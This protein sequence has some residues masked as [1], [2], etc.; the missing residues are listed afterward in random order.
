V[1]HAAYRTLARRHHPDT[2]HDRHA[3]ERIRAIN[4]AY[5]V[6]GNP[7]RRAQYDAERARASRAR[8]DRPKARTSGGGRG[9][10]RA[11][12]AL[13]GQGPPVIVVRVMLV[14][15]AIILL[16]AMLWGISLV[17]DMLEDTPPNLPPHSSIGGFSVLA[18]YD[19]L[20][21]PWVVSQPESWG[22]QRGRQGTAFTERV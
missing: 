15:V 22:T 2:S 5:E 20:A 8:G 7:V 17:Y 10:V 16:L 9:A 11:T 4:A 19:R 12:S 14:V 21:Q 18:L 1:I 13:A 3:A 6:L